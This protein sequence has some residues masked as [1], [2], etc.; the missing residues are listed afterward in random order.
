MKM[1]KQLEF[2]K[3]KVIILAGGKGTRMKV[4]CPRV[5][6]KALGRT[7]I[8]RVI[9][10]VAKFDSSLVPVVVVGYEGEKVAEQIKH[11]AEIAWQREQLGT[12][13][14][15]AQAK[16]KF[17][18]YSGAILILY[19]DH[20]LINSDTIKKLFD[21][22]HENSSVLTMMTTEVE[23]FQ[24]WR[25]GFQGFGRILRND[26]AEI[27]LI[28]EFKDCSDD[29]KLIKELNPGYYCF[30]S[31]WLWENVERLKNDNS[32]NEYYLTDLISLANTQNIKINSIQIN[33][34]ECLGI[35]TKEQLELIEGLIRTTEM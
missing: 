21:L 35:N 25:Q 29:E 22:H 27:Q 16:N 24:D 9:D 26:Q 1:S 15:V 6:V 31:Q 14:A 30:D 4:D 32:Q 19:G 28:Q 17:K 18:N 7:M 5:L 13:H 3:N 12:G 34:I 20:P 10:S 11:R 2:M 8:D 23:D 33:P